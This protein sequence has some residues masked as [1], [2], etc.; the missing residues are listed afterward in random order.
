[1]RSQGGVVGMLKPDRVAL[2]DCGMHKV[3]AEKAG[4]PTPNLPNSWNST[5]FIKHYFLNT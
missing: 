1:M 4:H 2:G 5:K 3:V